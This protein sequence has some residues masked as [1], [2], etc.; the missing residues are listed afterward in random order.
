L[1]FMKKYLK[2]SFADFKPMIKF[3]PRKS[4]RVV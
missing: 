3:A 4:G 2:I 1:V